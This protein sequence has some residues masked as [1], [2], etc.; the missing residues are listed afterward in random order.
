[1]PPSRTSLAMSWRAR[2][3]APW[4]ARVPLAQITTRCWSRG[5]SSTRCSSVSSGMLWTPRNL[6]VGHLVDLAYVEQVRTIVGIEQ[7]RSSYV[8]MLEIKSHGS[9]RKSLGLDS[10]ALALSRGQRWSWSM[11][12]CQRR[13]S[14]RAAR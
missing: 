4:R 5:T 12:E 6:P 11:Y 13:R 9:T 14:T 1:M 10:L 2:I 3:S 8:V 7:G